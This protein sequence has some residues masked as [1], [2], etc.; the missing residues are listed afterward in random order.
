MTDPAWEHSGRTPWKSLRGGDIAPYEF[1][2]YEALYVDVDGTLVFWPG[3]KP[4]RVPRKGEPHHGELPARNVALI[5]ALQAWWRRERQLVVWTAG[6][7]RHAKWAVDYCGIAS[8]TTAALA[9]PS[10]IVDDG[11][12]W[13]QRRTGYCRVPKDRG[14]R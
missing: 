14:E 8:I 7:Q 4:G 13:M 9:K 12:K 10:I 5:A 6:G 2:D 1:A 3:G 11:F